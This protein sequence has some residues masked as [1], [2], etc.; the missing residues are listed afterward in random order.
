MLTVPHLRR[1]IDR[2]DQ[3]LEKPG[4]DPA[5]VHTHD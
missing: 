2:L 5:P 1:A 4:E 3:V